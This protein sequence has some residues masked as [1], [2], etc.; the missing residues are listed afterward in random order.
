VFYYVIQ[1][2]SDQR[3]QS[4]KAEEL[5]EESDDGNGNGTAD[6]GE[7]LPGG[8]HAQPSGNG[9]AHAGTHVAH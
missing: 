5:D 8:E 2:F 6:S 1:W 4:R 7:G 9:V 3:M